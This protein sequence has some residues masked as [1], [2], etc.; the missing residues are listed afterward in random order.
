MYSGILYYRLRMVDMD[1]KFSYSPIKWV[2]FRDDNNQ[3]IQISP[4][5]VTNMAVIRFGAI[6]EG[7]YE[8]SVYNAEGRRLLI[9]KIDVTRNSSFYFPRESNMTPGVYIYNISGVHQIKTFTILYQ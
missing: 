6:A 8:V 4:N 5:P 1:G 2:S 3:Q 7:A 9:R